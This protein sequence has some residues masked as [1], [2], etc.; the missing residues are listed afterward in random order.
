[1]TP[2]HEVSEIKPS[3]NFKVLCPHIFNL[4]QERRSTISQP[5]LSSEIA[6]PSIL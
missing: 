5:Q 6:L 1:M 4:T 3:G 2:T